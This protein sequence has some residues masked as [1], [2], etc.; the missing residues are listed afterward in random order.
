[1]QENSYL[2]TQ[3]TLE[4]TPSTMSTKFFTNETENTLF[5][6]FRGIA[7][8]MAN[9]HSFHAVVGFFR[10]SGYFKL[11]DELNDVEK[12]QILVGINIDNIFRKHNKAMLMFGNE[13]E[14]KDIYSQDFINDVQTS[15]YSAPIEKGILQLCE[16]LHTGKVEMKIHSSKNLHAKF[17]LCLPQSHSAHSD[18][19]V[20]MGS[21]NISESGLGLSQAPRYE[22]NVAMKDFDDVSFCKKEFDK[23]WDEAISITA[24]DIEKSKNKTH[25]AEEQPTPYELYIKVLI[26]SFGDQVEDDFS[27]TLP[28]GV[29]DLK[30]QKDA[31]IQGYQMLCEHN[32]FFLADVVGLGK[33]IVATMIA[34]RFVEANG[35][36]TNILVV[37]PPALADNWKETFKQFG[38][39]KKAQFVSNGSLSKILEGRDNYKSKEEFDLIIIDE[40]HGFRSDTSNRY[41]ELQR[42]CKAPRQNT[43]LLK[44]EQ[45]KVMLLSATPLNNRPNDLQNQILLFQNSRQCTIDGI[46]N[47]QAFFAPLIDEYNEVMKTRDKLTDTSRIDTIYGKIR[48]KILDKITVRR[49]RKNIWN[50]D[51]YREDLNG[52]KIKFPDI[53]PPKD[54]NYQLSPKLSALFYATLKALTEDINYARYRAVEFLS[55]EHNHKFKNPVNIAEN[56]TGIYRVHMVKRLESSFY[57]FKR[58]LNTLLR[59]TEDM[60]GMFEQEKIIVAPELKVKDLQ[61]KGWELDRIIEYALEK[62]YDPKDIVFPP[63]AF[64]S[65][66]AKELLPLLK[67][68][69]KILQNLKSQWDEITEDPKLDLFI[70]T[71]KT[72]L[73]KKPQNPTGKLVVFSESVDTVNY[74]EESLKEKLDRKDILK[75]SSAN[76]KKD[77]EIIRLCFDANYKEQSDKF[78][79]VI[80]SDVLAEGVNLHRSNVIV[81]YDSPWNASRLMQRIGRV[82]R[83]GSVAGKIYNYMFY[84]SAQ[85]NEQIKLYQNALIKLQGFHSALGEDAQIYSKEEILKEFELFDKD[86]SDTVDKQLQ[87]LREVRDLYN[88]DRDLYK[89]IKKLP[90][91]SRAM[92]HARNLAESHTSVAFISSPRKTEY[93]KVTNETVESIDFLDATDILKATK[94]EQSAPFEIIAETHFAQVNRAMEKF[95]TESMKQQDT[96]SL[97]EKLKDPVSIEAISF[98]RNYK[99]ISNDDDVK[100]QCSALSQYVQDGVY[101]HLTRDVRALSRSYK[102]DKQAM[103]D[104]QFEIDRE[105]NNLYEKYYTA[106]TDEATTDNTEPN[107]VISETFV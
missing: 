105:L 91:K 60:I 78:N 54:L 92:R 71:L 33:T 81:N 79:I 46:S 30:Y 100:Q 41:D 2:C 56:L 51:S 89:K 86:V 24:N 63:H 5:D 8:N 15:G 19:W 17:Y 40:A 31:V 26:D 6:K 57:A 66:N 83:I 14:A 4:I 32:G 97:N 7:Q 93:Y 87:L 98:L 72:E 50:D 95:R 1:M 25:I 12:I 88:T 61:A 53:L 13:E 103:R 102:N 94:E 58:S 62:G 23:L 36:N 21:S 85:G 59:I 43:G 96:N 73:F 76:R 106:T 34:K 47:L 84:P 37:Y 3:N 27:I 52:Q 49:T 74:L 55:D 28:D 16:D 77:S 99:T 107:I 75:V 10:S 65:R 101:T 9:F 90:L 38:I 64:V 18:G 35:K 29:H 67:E 70:E 42:I 104:K 48:N 20:I 45:K 44:G 80:T 82:N 22:L 69:Q 39:T 11:R 68:D